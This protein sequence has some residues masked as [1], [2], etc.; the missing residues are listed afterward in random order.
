MSKRSVW[1][2][3][4]S[5]VRYWTLFRPKYCAAATFGI[6][7]HAASTRTTTRS[8]TSPDKIGD[9]TRRLHY[10]IRAGGRHPHGVLPEV[11]ARTPRT[12]RATLAWRTRSE[13]RRVG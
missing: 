8:T 6:A 9:G 13:E 7:T 11:A 12:R 10:G 2:T 3:R 5:N 4:K 1:R